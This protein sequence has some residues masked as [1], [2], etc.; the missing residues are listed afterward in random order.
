MKI[1]D[2]AG[3]QGRWRAWVPVYNTL[4]FVKLGDLNPWWLLVLWGG[5]IVARL[6][7]R[8]RLAHRPRRV[9][10]HAAGRVARRAEAAEGSRL[11]DPLLLPRDRVARHQR[12]RPLA[13]EHR[14]SRP[15]RGPA[16][17]SPTTPR[18]RASRPG[19]V[20]RLP[21]QPRHGAAA[22]APPPAT[23]RRAGYQPPPPAPPA[24]YEPRRPRRPPATRRPPAAPAARCGA[25]ARLPSRPRRAAA[26]RRRRAAPRRRPLPSRR[27]R[28]SR[29]GAAEAVALPTAPR[30]P[31]R[32][33]RARR[34][35]GT[36][37]PVGQRPPTA[38]ARRAPSRLRIVSGIAWTHDFD[39]SPAPRRRL[40][41]PRL[42]RR[43]RLQQLRS[44]GH[45]DRDARGHP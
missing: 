44:R 3:V 41:S 25:A 26:A 27:P 22:T 23:S 36:S 42:R 5:G 14:A 40:R 43:P 19:A 29:A 6:G 33:C 24:G 1:F 18:G 37:D 16:T 11:A 15:R 8:A 32:G 10:L 39:C 4:I 17:S 38:G 31:A 34:A 20:R 13:L 30:R 28:A 9:R 2:K 35:L 7:A 21:G 45:A 12:V